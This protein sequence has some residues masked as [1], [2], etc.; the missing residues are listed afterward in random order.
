MRSAD[1]LHFP[2]RSPS[3]S[4]DP[5][6]RGGVLVVPA[7]PLQ[8]RKKIV[9]GDGRSFSLSPHDSQRFLIFHTSPT[10]APPTTV[11]S[12][13]PPPV[14]LSMVCTQVRVTRLFRA[15]RTGIV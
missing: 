5:L 6:G 10:N 3:G 9:P 14:C 11:S 12:G 8:I 13:T 15:C 7:Y 1:V 2:G 4:A